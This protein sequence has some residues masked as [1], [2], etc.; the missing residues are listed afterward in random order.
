MLAV[1]TKPSTS[2]AVK[3][4]EMVTVAPLICVSSTSATVMVVSMATPT[5][6]SV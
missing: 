6:F 5:A 1:F 4:A 2:P 3:P